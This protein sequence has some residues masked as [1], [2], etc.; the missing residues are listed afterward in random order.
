MRK[1]SRRLPADRGFV[2]AKPHV[3][4][5]RDITRY[6]PHTV[7]YMLWGKAA[8]RCEFAGCNAILWKS[9]ITQEQVNIAQQAHIYSFSSRGPRGNQG[10]SAQQLND[11]RNLML[12]CHRCHRKLDREQD[13]GRYTVRLL[14]QM[15]AE[16]EQRIELVAGISSEKNSHV[17]LYGA[18]VGEH[19]SPLNYREAAP[20]LFPGRYPASDRPIELSTLKSSFLDRD[21]EF[22]AMEAESLRR[23]FDRQ[24]RERLA[25]GEIRHL[26]V[27][28]L[29]PQPL[30]I[31]LGSL[32]GDIVPADVYQRHREPQTWEWP[33]EEPTPDFELRTPLNTSGPPALVLALSATITPERITALLGSNPSIWTVTVPTPHNDLT[34]TRGQLS[35]FRTMLRSVLDQI[36]ALHGQAAV[37]HVF[38]A[39]SVS[40]AIELG[41]IRMPKAEMPWQIYDQVNVLGGFVRALSLPYG[42]KR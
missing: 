27:F 35:K 38:P 36:K 8:G 15:K 6:V 29:T 24:V 12:V 3:V 18:N 17:L 40:V 42:E 1:T 25:T 34:R 7:Q 13:G 19:S 39:A 30:L 4:V 11:L 32:L 21:G 31:M 2:P 10:I 14:E 16:H 37:L 20:A 26:S 28:S 23:K 5:P 33:I 22:W 41:R 9:P